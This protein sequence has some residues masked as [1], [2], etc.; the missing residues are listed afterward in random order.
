MKLTLH[1]S[2]LTKELKVVFNTDKQK[3][4]FWEKCSLCCV[5]VNKEVMVASQRQGN[6]RLTDVGMA[7]S[8]ACFCATRSPVVQWRARNYLVY[9]KRR[10]GLHRILKYGIDL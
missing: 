1:N 9:K 6:S 7:Y 4:Y 2:C 5:K 10:A 8:D 3:Q